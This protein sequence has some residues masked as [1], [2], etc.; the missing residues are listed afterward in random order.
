[1]NRILVIPIILILSLLSSCGYSEKQDVTFDGKYP[2]I[3]TITYSEDGE[4]FEIQAIAGH[5]IV[6]FTDTVSQPVAKRIIKD[7]GGKIIEQ[8]PAFNYYLVKVREG[9]ESRFVSS[10]NKEGSV[11]YAYFNT[12]VQLFSDV[13]IFDDFKN[14]N[15]SML[16]THGNGV[17]KTFSK[18]SISDDIHSVNM[19][20]LNDSDSSWRGHTTVSNIVLSNLLNVAKNVTN[21]DLTLI[22]MS[23]GIPLPGN[24]NHIKK[25]NDLDSNDQK[26]YIRQYAYELKQLAVCFDK[27]RDKGLSNFIVTK[28]SGNNGMHKMQAVLDLLDDKTI[29]LLKNNMVLVCA[30]DTK[31]KELYS[32]FPSEKHP[33]LTTVDVSQ[34]PWSGTSFASPQLMG[35]IDKIHNKY[36]NL[37][38]QKILQAIR[39]ATPENPTKPLTYEML[40][41]EVKNIAEQYGDNN[42]RFSFRLELTSNYSGE[43]DLSDGNRDEIVRYEV[44][45]TYEHDYLSGAVKGLYLEN[46]TGKN[47]NIYLNT[48]DSERYIRPMHYTLAAD[49]KEGFYAYRVGTM[50][51]LSVKKMEVQ[52]STW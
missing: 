26:L 33:L 2:R 1:M 24:S 21:E 6:F 51:I 37:N 38:A 49:E 40:E 29:N 47:L 46:K 25:Y 11:E 36:E 10:I 31:S 50:E 32:N 39:N 35:F 43:W 52:L 19:V 41:L 5:C 22:N 7:G 23:F 18:Y 8:I 20:F 30:H 27:M 13:Y 12:L 4:D 42:K 17:R 9:E 15:E 48:I 14:V 28:S 34:E 45:N 16:T 3:T 44:H